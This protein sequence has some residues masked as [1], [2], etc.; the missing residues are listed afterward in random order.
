MN[1]NSTGNDEGQMLRASLGLEIAEATADG[2]K[3]RIRGYANTFGVMRSKRI[4][5]PAA[6]EDW[7]RANPQPRLPLLAQHGFVQGFATIGTI[8]V[9]KADRKRG[10]YFEASV[11]EGIELADQA[12][13]LITQGMLN[14]LSI[15]WVTSQARWVKVDD[16]DLDGWL[17]QQM[18][19]AGVSEVQAFFAVEVLEISLVDVGDDRSAKLAARA[20]A[21][22]VETA[23]APLREEL[24]ALREQL[25]RGGASGANNASGASNAGSEAEELRRVLEEQT[26]AFIEEFKAAAIEALANDEDL[27][28]TA[29]DRAREWAALTDTNPFTELAERVTTLEQQSMRAELDKWGLDSAKAK[30]A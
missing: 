28:E 19:E 18:K 17:A 25:A 29:A 21:A 20:E 15:G 13:K 4:I 16:K 22:A 6:V 8:D 3:R 12:W 5:H 24:A 30:K 2:G 23:L 26:D 14:S 10:M 1:R 7:L 11:A 27:H 9:V